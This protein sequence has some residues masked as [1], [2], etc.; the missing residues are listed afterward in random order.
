MK[1]N[2]KFLPENTKRL[3]EF[4]I[5]EKFISD[6]VLVGR[7]ALSLLIQHRLSEDLDFIYQGKELDTKKIQRFINVN[8]KGEYKLLKKD[9]GHQIDYLIRGVKVTFFTT[10]AVSVNFDVKKNSKKEK[11]LYVADY[12]IISV[13]KLLAISQ[14]TAIRDYYDL[15]FLA[16]KVLPLNK[17]FQL[18]RKLLP[19]LSEITYKETLIYTDDIDEDSISTLLKP[20]IKITKEKISEFFKKELIKLK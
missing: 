19:E 12:K 17:I 5:E 4:F 10:D 14:R 13:L 6:Y 18:S 8:F 2:K 11:N 7:T 16:K 3:F 9:N 20:K 1:P 15:Y